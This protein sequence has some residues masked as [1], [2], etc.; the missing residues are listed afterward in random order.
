MGLGEP[1]LGPLHQ[2]CW[3]NLK[4]T[5][6]REQSPEQDETTSGPKGPQ[7]QLS[8]LQ[9]T[10]HPSREQEAPATLPAFLLLPLPCSCWDP[11]KKRH[12]PRGC[13][14]SDNSPMPRVWKQ[15]SH[16]PHP[17]PIHV[18]NLAASVPAGPN[19][20]GGWVRTDYQAVSTQHQRH[21][22][23]GAPLPPHAISDPASGTKGKS[24]GQCRC[25]LSPDPG[26][27][28][29]GSPLQGSTCLPPKVLW[30]RLGA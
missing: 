22:R 3:G 25:C 12:W 8:I 27:A 19:V 29:A 6:H 26:R 5:R 9:G 23:Q 24:H 13:P 11:S 21:P 17:D 1:H 14:H 4:K 18:L 15:G 7:T 2:A 20:W 28:G 16:L 30:V 10:S